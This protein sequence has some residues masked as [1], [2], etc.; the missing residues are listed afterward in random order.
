[1]AAFSLNYP[2]AISISRHHTSS[3]LLPLPPP[4]DDSLQRNCRERERDERI[5]N[6]IWFCVT[7]EGGRGRLL[8][9]G[10]RR[11][12]KLTHHCHTPTFGRNSACSLFY[13]FARCWQQQQFSKQLLLCTNRLKEMQVSFNMRHLPQN[14]VEGHLKEMKCRQWEK[15]SWKCDS[16][17][18]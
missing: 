3:L 14:C 9:G 5:D 15:A 7:S 17:T 1:M 6:V 10:E 12:Q 13:S 8:E 4:R 16:A 2:E 11:S 18:P